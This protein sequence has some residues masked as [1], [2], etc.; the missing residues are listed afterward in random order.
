MTPPRNLAGLSQD[1]SFLG[2]AGSGWAL[3]SSIEN[4]HARPD[5]A[6]IPQSDLVL[7]HRPEYSRIAKL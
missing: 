3:V 7:T 1:G 4:D 2:E 6:P 5:A